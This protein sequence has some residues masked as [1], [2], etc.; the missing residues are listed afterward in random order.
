MDVMERRNA[1]GNKPLVEI[2]GFYA[3]QLQ[4]G[5]TV[6]FFFFLDQS[7]PGLP[8]QTK[9]EIPVME[10]FSVFLLLQKWGWTLN[11]CWVCRC[12]PRGCLKVQSFVSFIMWYGCCFHFYVSQRSLCCSVL[13]SLFFSCVSILLLGI[14]QD[15]SCQR[16]LWVR[17]Q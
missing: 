5:H 17:A 11:S 10:L 4:F 15:G 7:S 3:W 14:D 9:Q 2:Y 1:H 13:F 8:I 16:L 6:L 12:E